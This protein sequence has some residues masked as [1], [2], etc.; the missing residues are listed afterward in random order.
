MTE[1]S[2]TI[3]STSGGQRVTISGLGFNDLVFSKIFLG[4]AKCEMEYGAMQMIVCVTSQHEEGAVNLQVSISTD[5]FR[6]NERVEQCF[7]RY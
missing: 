2:P 1:I 5:F 7:R 3:G 6:Q 4:T